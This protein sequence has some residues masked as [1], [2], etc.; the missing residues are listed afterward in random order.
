M[1]PFFLAIAVLVAVPAWAA[2]ATARGHDTGEVA[3]SN[4]AFRVAL[5]SNAA[6]A[7]RASQ[8]LATLARQPA[9]A[10]LSKPE[11]R[12]YA[13]HTKYLSES[14]ARLA[15]VHAK[16]EQV[17]AKGDKAPITEVATTNMELVNARD[18]IEADGKRFAGLAKP[19]KPRHVSAMSA[20]RSEK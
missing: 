17:L 14:A 2:P 7:R 9:P 1:R 3:P 15:S 13:E 20:V 19:A 12:L 5:I 10:K 16:M 8:K 4:G 6:A 18:A 11:L